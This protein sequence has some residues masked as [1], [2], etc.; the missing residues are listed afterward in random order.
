MKKR[1]FIALLL[2][3]LLSTY[4][5]QNNFSLNLNLNVEK[6]IIENNKILNETKIK[7]NLLPLYGNNLIFLNL[8]SI[9]TILEKIDFIDSYEVKKI[10]PNKIKI[11]IF[12][13]KPIAI[14]QN[15]KEKKYYTKE[16][17]LVNYRNYEIFKNLPLV[18]GDQENFK[19]FY[20]KLNNIDFPINEIK[21]FYLFESKRWDLVTKKNQT[22]KL[23]I[24]N[25]EES[26]KNFII[27]KDQENF[28]KYSSFDYRI[29]NQLI[30]K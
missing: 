23:P 8:K 10:Y 14:L 18:F 21:T 27:L 9:E 11:K 3:L 4:N 26:L 16:G 22:I 13:V 30:L 15:K 20:K 29:K 24:E 19:I 17:K 6:I 7:K 12:E 5:L 2:L 28:K 25:Y 1:F